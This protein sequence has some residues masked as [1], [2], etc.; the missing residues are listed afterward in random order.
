MKRRETAASLI[1]S[2]AHQ[3]VIPPSRPVA[4][5]Y[6]ASSSHFVQDTAMAVQP[7]VNWEDLSM[8]LQDDNQ[9][10]EPLLK[11]TPISSPLHQI[12]I[13][14]SAFSFY[15]L[16]AGSMHTSISRLPFRSPAH[17]TPLPRLS[18]GPCRLVPMVEAWVL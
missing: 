5:S 16:D 12:P 4:I 17:W 2:R 6:I 9:R 10:S 8:I 13:W 18:V 3:P 15:S 1:R 11:S 14:L 7:Q